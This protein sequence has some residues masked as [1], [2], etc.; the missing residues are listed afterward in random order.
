MD[1]EGVLKEAVYAIWH[2]RLF[3]LAG[4]FAGREICAIV[5]K[6]KDGELIAKALDVLGYNLARG[7]SSRGGA[8]ALLQML[9]NKDYNKG[10]VVT[11]DGPRGP[12]YKVKDGVVFLALKSGLPIIPVSYKISKSFTINSWD[13]FIIPFPFS[14]AQIIFGEPF[15]VKEDMDLLASKEII[16]K[17]LKIISE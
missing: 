1:E 15:F 16:E 2:N 4:V 9:K 12:C 11:V 10:F 3:L 7:S 8:Q 13:K 14:S 6:S 5:S 17:K